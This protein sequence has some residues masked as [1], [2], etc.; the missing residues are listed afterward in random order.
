[1]NELNVD[2]I[3]EMLSTHPA[4]ESRALDLEASLPAVIKEKT[5]NKKND[6][7]DSCMCL[8]NIFFYILNY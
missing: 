1:M 4:N 3:P 8:F 7:H 5:H 2:I 6:Y